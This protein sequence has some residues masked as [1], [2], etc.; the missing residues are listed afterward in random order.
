MI[1]WLLPILVVA[2]WTGMTAIANYQSGSIMP[3]PKQVSAMS[4]GQAFLG[5]R[6]AVEGYMAAN[7]SFT[8]N[9]PYASLVSWLAP[10]Q[11]LPPGAG[12]QVNLTPSGFGKIMYSWAQAVP[13][14][15]WAAVS[16][17]GGDASIGMVS[18]TQ[19]ISPIYGV[20]NWVVPSF[21]PNGDILSVVQ[22][23][24]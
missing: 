21:V 18:G 4:A 13:G 5:Y 2:F 12:N 6:N 15:A 9:I 3:S 10:G 8:G 22:T 17:T 19:W 1:F 20:Q 7:P 24:S 16:T 11:P 23:G 14:E